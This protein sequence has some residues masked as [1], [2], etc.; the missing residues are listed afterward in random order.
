MNTFKNYINQVFPDS[1]TAHFVNGRRIMPPFPEEMTLATFG[2]GC[3]WGVEKR[4]WGLDGVFC[5][6]VGYAG[7][8]TQN[9]TYQD[10]CSGETNHA[11]VV[12]IVFNSQRIDYKDLIKIFWEAHNPTQGM[13]QGNDVGT[14]YR[15]VIFTHSEMQHQIALETRDAYQKKLALSNYPMITTE[16]AVAPTFYYAELYHQQYLAKNPDG[17]CGLKGTGICF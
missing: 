12:Q 1:E 11:E 17:Y 9:P 14:Q 8:S 10:V 15:S 7:G 2:M 4:F 3:F 16:I 13:K 5:T 6:A